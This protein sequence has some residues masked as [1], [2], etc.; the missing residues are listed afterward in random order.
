MDGDAGELLH[1][2][3]CVGVV[4]QRSLLTLDRL[5][6][7]RRELSI[8]CFMERRKARERLVATL[9]QESRGPW[10]SRCHQ[11]WDDDDLLRIRHT[12]Q[13]RCARCG[14]DP[15]AEEYLREAYAEHRWLSVI[16]AIQEHMGQCG[17]C[18]YLGAITRACTDALSRMGTSIKQEKLLK[19]L[20]AGTGWHKPEPDCHAT[21]NAVRQYTLLAGAG[22]LLLAGPPA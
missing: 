8:S 2:P 9:C 17:E 18:C 7:F 5:E 21:C 13:F 20:L 4:R 3:Y 19:L 6:E 14:H 12:E 22:M 1:C 11:R 15:A 16:P 10:C